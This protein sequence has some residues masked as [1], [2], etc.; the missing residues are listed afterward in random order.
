[1]VELS[2]GACSP[3]G[4]PW[5][6]HER[7]RASFE[8]EWLLPLFVHAS[9]CAADASGTANA[10]A[11]RLMSSCLSWDFARSSSSHAALSFGPSPAA[12][13]QRSLTDAPAL[14]EPPAAWATALLGDDAASLPP[15]VWLPSLSSRVASS[16]LAAAGLGPGAA[17]AAGAAARAVFCQLCGLRGRI[18]GQVAG[19]SGDAPG[20]AAGRRQRHLRSC[21]AAS[22]AFLPDVRSAAAAA[23]AGDSEAEAALLDVC[24]G[25]AVLAGA[26]PPSDW[27]VPQP[28]P[29]RAA[30]ESGL[31]VLVSSALACI[32]A[33]GAGDSG[34]FSPV[35]DATGICLEALCSLLRAG[36]SRQ[37]APGAPEAAALQEAA[38]TVFWAYASSAMACAAVGAYEDDDGDDETGAAGACARD[39]RLVLVAALARAA[40]NMSLPPLASALSQRRAALGAAA[41]AGSD[42]AV[43]LEELTWLVRRLRNRRMRV[44]SGK[45]RVSAPHSGVPHI[46]RPPRAQVRMAAHALA[47]GGDGETPIPPDELV[48]AAAA[49]SAAG[50]KD[51]GCSL[52]EELFATCTLCLQPGACAALSARLM[53][54]VCWA[55]ARWADTYLMPEDTGGSVFGRALTAPGAQPAGGALSEAAGGGSALEALLRLSVCALSA[56]PG[57][58]ALARE[59]SRTLLPVLT[60]RRTLCRCALAT[61]AWSDLLRAAAARA[62][63]LD[64]LP[65]QVQ[66]PLRV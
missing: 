48:E 24:R 19:T 3:L 62:P 55:A 15:L 37:A 8:A 5:E 40:P 57:E 20:D 32:T 12:V 2:P 50:Q 41:A 16:D 60:R 7:C 63:P 30:P 26:H 35:G 56:W 38:A 51:S 59:A 47:D 14:M 64:A 52:A 18:F 29:G 4:L 49:A 22:A 13:L 36:R 58:V 45:G 53:E 43:C 23:A 39:E 31:H 61:A 65:P 33:G 34:Q 10:A 44:L 11:A 28:L 54:S 9:R 25:L 6:Y 1:M 46:R 17:A 66:R 42:T 21:L 27:V